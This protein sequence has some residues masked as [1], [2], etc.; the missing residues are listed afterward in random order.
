[1]GWCLLLAM[2]V[3]TQAQGVAKAKEQAMEPAKMFEF[4]SGMWINLHHMLYTQA[5]SQS[6]RPHGRGTTLE[7]DDTAELGRMSAEDKAAWNGAVACYAA[8]VIQRDLLFD[9]GMGDIKNK[10]E[11]A[12]TST[13]L[14]GVAVPVELKAALL[15][16]GPVYRRV[17]WARHDA[18]NRR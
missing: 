3:G 5:M 9:R 8:S 2:G 15:K 11:A 1:M 4:H 17:F 13:D 6:S 18:G 10:L 12:E 14:D 16:A 7:A